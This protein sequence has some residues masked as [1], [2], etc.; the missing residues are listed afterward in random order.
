MAIFCLIILR[1]SNS[2]EQVFKKTNQ[3]TKTPSDKTDRKATQGQLRQIET[4]P[5]KDLKST[6]PSTT[7]GTREPNIKEP[8]QTT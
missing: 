7:Q 4:L 3:R 8:W 1:V 2:F 6:A 5:P